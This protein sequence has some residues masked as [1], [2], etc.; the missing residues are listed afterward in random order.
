MT[1][2]NPSLS[3]ITLIEVVSAPVKIQIG[4]IYLKKTTTTMIQ[5]YVIYRKLTLDPKTQMI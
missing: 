1:G 4:R 3:V 5:L 2:V